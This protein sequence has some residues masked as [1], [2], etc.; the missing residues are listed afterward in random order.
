MSDTH[1]IIEGTLIPPGNARFGVVASRF[2]DFIVDRLVGGAMDAFT[3][4]GVSADR[5]TLVRV[6]GS[7]ELP[8]VC[9]RLAK[10]GKLDAVIALGAVIRGGTPH[11]DYVAAEAAK[12]VAA[13]SAQSG[14]PVVFGVLT[15][16]SIEQAIE[17]AGTKMGNKGFDAAMAAIE[18]VSLAKALGDA[19]L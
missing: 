12:G 9:A 5:V 4:H 13:A 16:D 17:R 11:F 14:V 1:K 8:L 15:T 18:M 3:R 19:G 7:W 10:S 6:P 2:N